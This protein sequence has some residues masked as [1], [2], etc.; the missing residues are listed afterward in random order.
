V[1]EK[2]EGRR[3]IRRFFISL[4]FLLTVFRTICAAEAVRILVPDVVRVEG[5]TCA[6]ADVA[7]IDGPSELTE[8]IGALPLLVEN[9]IL[10]REQVIEALKVSGLQGVRIELKMPEVVRVL[11]TPKDVPAEQ[12]SRGQNNEALTALIKSL[13]A[14]DGDVE[15]QYRG[16]VPEG[17]LTAPVSIVPGTSA[18]TLRFRD[19]SGKERSLA[20]RFVWTCWC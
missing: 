3:F 14:W 15:V 2:I 5:S 13:A 8:R 10:V 11:S 12:A 4:I 7:E 16:A 17:R 1:N 6:L 19:S 9:R 18:A 20:V